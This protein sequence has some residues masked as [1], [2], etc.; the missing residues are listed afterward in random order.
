[1]DD[2]IFKIL[3]EELGRFS[4]A[5]FKNLGSMVVFQSIPTKTSRFS[6]K[7]GFPSLGTNISVN[8]V[9]TKKL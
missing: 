6:G 3:I 7:A 2:R 1:M 8:T 9:L 5:W 4:S